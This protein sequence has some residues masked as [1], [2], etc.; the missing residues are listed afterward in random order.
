MELN[1]IE[2]LKKYNTEADIIKIAQYIDDGVIFRKYNKKEILCIVNELLKIDL[3]SIKYET[4]EEI[5][6]LLCDVIAYYGILDNVRWEKIITIKDKL[7]DDL[8]EYISEFI[9]S[10]IN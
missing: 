10:G 3:L 9:C 7:E 8:Q 1:E 4:R 5:L 2:K 6:H